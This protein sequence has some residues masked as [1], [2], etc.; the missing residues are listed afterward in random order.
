MNTLNTVVVGG[1]QAGLSV[2]HYLKQLSVDH[3]VLEQAD[4]PGEAWRNHRWDSVA[5]NTPRWQ[6]RLPGVRYGE[7][8]PD[9]F[10][11]SRKSWRIWTRWHNG[12][13]SAPAHASSLSRA[14]PPQA[15]ILSRSMVA[16]R[17]GRAT[18]WWRRASIRRPRFRGSAAISLQASGNFT[19]T[20]IAIRSS[21]CRVPYWSSVARSRAHKSRKN[22]M[23]TG[24]R[25][26]SPSAAPA[27]PRGVIAARTRTGGTTSWATTIRRSPSCRRPRPNSPASRTFRA[28]KAATPLRGI[29][30]GIV[31]LKGDLHDN[32]A[33]A[34]RA[35][36]DFV[37]TVD[38]YIAATGMSARQKR[39]R[40]CVTGSI[41]Q[42]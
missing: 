18:S 39:Y 25:S 13:R 2:G 22:S 33:E 36:A 7:D 11:P 41:K 5:L 10:M 24:E 4:K 30:G 9:G 23:S 12:C 38:A 35:E 40:S 19:P 8:D 29:E 27:A 37:K 1:G 42:S 21:G 34:D 20:A 17:L 16:R 6:S 32:L 28:R 31:E 26:I 15:T 3:V 14:T